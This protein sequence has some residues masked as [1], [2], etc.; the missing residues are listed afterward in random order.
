MVEREMKQ[1]QRP[2]KQLH[3]VSMEL[4]T[5]A[6]MTKNAIS[7]NTATIARCVYV[8]SLQLT[9][10]SSIPTTVTLPF[11]LLNTRDFFILSQILFVTTR[12]R[13]TQADI[14]TSVMGMPNRAQN[15]Q[16][17][18]PPGDNGDT[19][20]QPMVVNTVPEKNTAW[21]NDQL[22]STVRLFIADMPRLLARTIF[23]IKSS[24]SES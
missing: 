12:R 7:T 13:S 5:A 18:L 22:G 16:N 14:M 19:C 23:S 2:S 21:P 10:G 15:M 8:S 1:Q 24:R 11:L 6:G 3:S 4:N 9:V 20:P 17:T